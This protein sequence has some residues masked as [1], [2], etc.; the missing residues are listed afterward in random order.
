MHHDWLMLLYI[1][2][3]P[4]DGTTPLWIAA[5]MGHSEVVKVLLLRGADRDAERNVR[6]CHYQ[7][8]CSYQQ[9]CCC[10]KNCNG[11]LSEVLL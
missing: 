11:T 2:L 10:Y 3:M 6:H 7:Q 5:Q 4:Q 1:Y 9:L 8:L